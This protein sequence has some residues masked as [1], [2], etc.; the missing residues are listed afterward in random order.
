M[1]LK[2]KRRQR[3]AHGYI[4]KVNSQQININWSFSNKKILPMET[5]WGWKGWDPELNKNSSTATVQGLSHG[6]K[7]FPRN[8]LI[9]S[10]HFLF[11]PLHYLIY[12]LNSACQH[13]VIL[14]VLLIVCLSRVS[15]W[16]HE[17]RNFY[18]IHCFIS[19]IFPGT[20]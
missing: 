13:L 2:F 17:D 11:Y 18:P 7:S 10:W 19:R 20:K 8:F 16:L 1:F 12:F 5:P 15:Y 4:M 9:I 3:F 6:P 14:V